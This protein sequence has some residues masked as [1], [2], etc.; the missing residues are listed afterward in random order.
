MRTLHWNSLTKTSFPNDSYDIFIKKFNKIYDE[1]SPLKS[2]AK[3][4]LDKPWNYNKN[5]DNM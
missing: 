5:R 2:K 3:Q 1:A 4:C